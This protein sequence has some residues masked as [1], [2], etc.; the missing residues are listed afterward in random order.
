MR[1]PLGNDLNLGIS[2]DAIE[3]SVSRAPSATNISIFA[4]APA[5]ANR[6]SWRTDLGSPTI[7]D[8]LERRVN[9][10]ERDYDHGDDVLSN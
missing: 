6:S 2:P 9:D 3:A 8:A 10:L 4:E 5:S 7:I 1:Q